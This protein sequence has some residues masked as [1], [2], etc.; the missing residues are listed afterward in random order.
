MQN[1]GQPPPGYQ[2]PGS[3]TS[4]VG[5]QPPPPPQA[6][7][8]GGM[9]SN[10]TLRDAAWDADTGQDISPLHRRHKVN[11]LRQLRTR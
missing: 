10:I 9:R 8:Y 4:F 11:G 2:R 6:S 7:G 5:Q 3:T 1:Y